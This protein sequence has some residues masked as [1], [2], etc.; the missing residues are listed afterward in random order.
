MKKGLGNYYSSREH[1]K[2]VEFTEYSIL[3][4]LIKMVCML[5]PLVMAQRVRLII[6][7]APCKKRKCDKVNNAGICTVAKSASILMK[8]HQRHAIK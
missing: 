4:N 1:T 7:F 6:T 5:V 3:N 2:D 8:H